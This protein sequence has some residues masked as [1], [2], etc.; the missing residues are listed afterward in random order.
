MLEGKIQ[1][2]GQMIV[3][4]TRL[5]LSTWV[6]HSFTT[7]D[8]LIFQFQSIKCFAARFSPETLM[9]E[10]RRNVKKEPGNQAESF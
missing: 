10:I 2:K 6:V 3:H 4:T 8:V 5:K 1:N 9:E 7:A